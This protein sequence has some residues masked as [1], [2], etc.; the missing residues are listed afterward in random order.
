MENRYYRILNICSCCNQTISGPEYKYDNPTYKPIYENMRKR[1]LVINVD[2]THRNVCC[3]CYYKARK[4]LK[5]QSNSNK[6]DTVPVTSSKQ[7]S[8]RDK[9]MTRNT[10]KLQMQE[11]NNGLQDKRGQKVR[12][13][14]AIKG[15]IVLR[16]VDPHITLEQFKESIQS[17]ASS[18]FGIESKLKDLKSVSWKKSKGE[19]KCIA[20]S[21]PNENT[22]MANIK[23]NSEYRAEFYDD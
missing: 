18:Y 9:I 3:N 17:I 23:N 12:L 14:V 22:W 13:F 8:S 21:I 4:I 1:E 2:S 6:G 19:S 11:M 16:H 20:L 5:S 7:V 10:E 15:E